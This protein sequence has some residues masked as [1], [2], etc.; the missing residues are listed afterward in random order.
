MRIMVTG[1]AGFVGSHV[2]RRLLPEHEVLVVDNLDPYYAPAWKQQRLDELIPHPNFRWSRIDILDAASLHHA[3]AAFRPDRVL[4][5]AA[6]PGVQPSLLDPAAYVDVDVKG[7]VNLL[8]LSAEH[9]VERFLFVSSSSVYGTE[10]EGPCAED[11]ELRPVSPYA[12]AKA[13]GETFA[14]TYERLYGLPVTIVRPFTVYGPEQRPDMAMFKFATSILRG[15]PITVYGKEIGR[16]YIFVEDVADGMV[17][18]ALAEQAA[19]RTY[20]IGSGQ[21]VLIRDVVAELERT[22]GRTARVEWRDLPMGDV[23]RT[24]ANMQRAQTELSF[25]ARVPF[26]AGLQRFVEWYKQEGVGR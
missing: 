18:A 17:R 11:R 26:A 15:E 2:V 10:I 4:H 5:L 9:G 21:P 3:F 1:G 14:R 16:D 24:W 7:T 12:A 23:P 19:G 13:A 22:L 8:A 20:N 25:Q 6:L